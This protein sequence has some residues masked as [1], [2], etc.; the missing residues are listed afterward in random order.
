MFV[1]F[2]WLKDV[3]L[4]LNIMKM[5]NA[6]DRPG[7]TGHHFFSTSLLL[8]ICSCEMDRICMSCCGTGISILVSLNGISIAKIISLFTASHSLMFFTQKDSWMS[9]ELRPHCL[10][11]TPG[12]GFAR[13]L[14]SFVGRS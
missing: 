10:T 2:V 9:I 7:I 8:T 5:K 12:G 13:I 6:L 1:L 3:L 11:I 14:S 4:H